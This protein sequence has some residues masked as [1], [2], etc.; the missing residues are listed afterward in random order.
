M[1]G[2]VAAFPAA[3][4][5]GVASSPRVGVP[6]VPCAGS[7]GWWARDCA[8]HAASNRA[9]RRLLAGVRLRGSPR[10]GW[11]WGGG[12]PFIAAYLS[13]VCALV[14][15]VAPLPSVPF[16]FL[17]LRWFLAPVLCR[18]R[19]LVP[20]GAC[21]LPWASPRPLAAGPPFAVSL[22]G[23][24]VV[25]SGGGLWG[26]DGRSLGLGGLEPPAD[27]LR[28]VGGAEALD[29]IPEESFHAACGMAASGAATSRLAGLQV[30]ISSKVC[31]MCTPSRL[32]A[33]PALF[34][35][36]RSSRRAVAD[37]HPRW[38]GALG[39]EGSELEVLELRWRGLGVEDAY[40][41]RRER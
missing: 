6:S 34:T 32:P 21:L 31:T 36:R 4:L 22:P 27:G 16:L 13:C 2:C 35:Q 11:G 37:H 41:R 15:A 28:G 12:D 29:R 8:A 33:P 24:V 18:P 17:A 39:G 10:V 40:G 25:G 20:V 1:V 19:C 26:A 23:V 9:V 14:P 7:V 3:P 5:V 38:A 30:R